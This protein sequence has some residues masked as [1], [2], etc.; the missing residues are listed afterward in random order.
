[1][2]KGKSNYLYPALGYRAPVE[3]QEGAGLSCHQI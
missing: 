3:A 1:M 2:E